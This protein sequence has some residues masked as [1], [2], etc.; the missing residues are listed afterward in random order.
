MSSSDKRIIKVLGIV[1]YGID[2]ANIQDFTGFDEYE[3]M[4]M[5]IIYSLWD[6]F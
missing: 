2:Y 4:F 1:V 6:S 5:S 3:I